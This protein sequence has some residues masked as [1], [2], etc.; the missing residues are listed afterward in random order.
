M[1]PISVCIIAKDEE[2]YI[3]ECL[4]RLVKVFSEIIV[5]DTGSADRTKAIA[6]RYTKQVYHFEWINDFSAARNYASSKAANDWILSVD[7]DEYLLTEPDKLSRLMEQLTDP[8]KIGLIIRQNPQASSPEALTSSS[9]ALTSSSGA[10]ASTEYISRLFSKSRYHFTGSIHEQ[11]A[12]LNGSE[13]LFQN[14]PLAFYHVGYADAST[15]QKKAER[16]LGLLMAELSV[17]GEDPY[18]FFQ[19]GQC[20]FSVHRYEEALPYFDKGL[21]FDLNPSLEYVR[22]M[23]ESYGYCLLNT[24][25]YEQALS[26]EGVYEEFCR[27]SDFLFLMG[28]IYM[29]NGLLERAIEEF[30]N[31]VKAPEHVADGV[32]S[33]RAYYNI[34]I[35]YECS[36]DRNSALE[37]YR[38]CGDFPPARE[39]LQNF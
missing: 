5:V 38:K 13:K 18:L 37:Y 21:S 4:K 27:R 3:D 11:L 10:N 35:I 25:R 39:R 8:S 23:V 2:Q 33:Y 6:G 28:L 34:G 14:V 12:S 32:N 7:C 26:L 19:I 15:L 36:G 30:L 16:N 9:E 17:H 20:Y 24:K 1:L 29:N 31:A 22:T